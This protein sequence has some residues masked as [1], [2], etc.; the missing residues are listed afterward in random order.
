MQMNICL[1]DGQCAH[2]RGIKRENLTTEDP[3]KSSEVLQMLPDTSHKY[4]LEYFLC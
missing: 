2:L 4:F 3:E 1:N